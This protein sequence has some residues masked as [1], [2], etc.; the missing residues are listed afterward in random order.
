MKKFLDI[1][2]LLWLALLLALAGSLKHLAA[3]FAIDVGNIAPAA[4]S[5]M[6][7]LT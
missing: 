6:Q 3:I 7:V 5:T 1:Q 2:L 4:R